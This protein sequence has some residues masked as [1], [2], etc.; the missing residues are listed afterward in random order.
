V[1]EI[2]E[3][4]GDQPYPMQLLLDANNTDGFLRDWR[5]TVMGPERHLGYAVQWFGLAVTLMIIYIVVN[6]KK[7]TST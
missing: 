2:G 5:P 6:M 4:L 3:Q 7:T 1:T